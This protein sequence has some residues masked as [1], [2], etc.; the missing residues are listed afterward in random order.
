MKRCFYL[1]F[2]LFLLS[3]DSKTE[4]D[5]PGQKGDVIHDTVLIDNTIPHSANEVKRYMWSAT[6]DYKKVR[7]IRFNVA[8]INAD[9][10]IKGLN[11]EYAEVQL[12]KV[13]V[14]ND[15]IY[16]RIQN[17]TYLSEQMGSTGAEIYLAEVVLNLTATPGIKYV[18]IMLQ[19]GSHMQ[20]GTWSQNDFK[21]YTE[22][23]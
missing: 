6:P 20:P 11:T 2:A 19:E 21:K 18:N 4:N 14:S 17:A 9:S 16:T 22:A 10:I 1:L 7:N 15:T 5:Q 3:C 8:V 23:K 13:K 12:E